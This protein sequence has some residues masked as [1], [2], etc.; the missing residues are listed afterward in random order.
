MM[1]DVTH[2]VQKVLPQD[3]YHEEGG[4]AILPLF[5]EGFWHYW[6][7]NAYLTS[8]IWMHWEKGQKICEGFNRTMKCDAKS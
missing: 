6:E 7:N 1:L 3:L 8:I 2:L 4:T 5:L